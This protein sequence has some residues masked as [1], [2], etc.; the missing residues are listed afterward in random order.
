MPLRYRKRL[1]LGPVTLNVTQR[2]ITSVS[3][4][5]GPIT[6]NPTRRRITTDLPGGL[7]H[8]HRTRRTP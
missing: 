2:G 3:I 1:K 4:K 7:Y 6:W 5:L 8:E